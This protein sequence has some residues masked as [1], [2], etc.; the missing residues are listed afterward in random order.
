[1]SAGASGVRFDNGR[2]LSTAPHLLALAALG[3]AAGAINAAAGGGSLLTFPALVALGL[4]ALT[5]NISNSVA[6]TPGY[7]VIAHG[8]RRELVGQRE[9]IALLVPPAV[10]GGALGV[11]LLELGSRATFRAVAPALVLA[12]CVLLVLQDRLR[13]FIRR[14]STDRASRTGLR[15]GVLLAGA[16][17]AY[18]GAAAG[19]LLLAVLGTFLHDELQRLNALSRMLILIISALAAIVFVVLGPISWVAVL[20]LAPTTMIGGRL[21]VVLVRRFSSDALRACVLVI[22]VAASVYLIATSW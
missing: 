6:Q 11:A 1:M 12:A 21:G 8:Y 18:F 13:E 2:L 7:L 4:P 17:T 3:V 14:T 22:G 9:R 16:Y 20:V 10:V 15:L 5:A 19:V